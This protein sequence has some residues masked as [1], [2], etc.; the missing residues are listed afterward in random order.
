M[1]IVID[2]SILID[3][4]RKE[5]KE[6]SRFYQL[7]ERNHSFAISVIT[8]YEIFVGSNGIQDKYW[9]Q[10]FE[11]VEILPLTSEIIKEAVQIYRRM[12]KSNSLIEIPDILI[13]A[14]AKYHNL[15]IATLNNK[16][17]DRI[18]GLEMV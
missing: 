10:F 2:T 9:N 3:F 18:G 12:K 14:T 1:K 5:K 8:E 4:Y 15:K 11:K 7:I 16:H 6:K 17:F 13:G